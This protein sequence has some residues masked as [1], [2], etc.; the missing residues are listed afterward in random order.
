MG[1]CFQAK[2]PHFLRLGSVNAVTD[3]HDPI[4]L[5]CRSYQF[6]NASGLLCHIQ[7]FKLCKAVLT[8]ATVIPSI[9][10]KI[11][12]DIFPETFIGET[13]KSHLPQSFQV[14]FPDQGLFLKIQ[15]L[16]PL[17][18]DQKFIH[19][20][21]LSLVVKDTLPRLSVPACTACFLVVAFNIFGHIVMDHKPDIRFVNPHT[22]G[23]GSHHDRFSVVDKVFLVL[24]LLPVRKSCMIP[25]CRIAFPKKGF[26]NLFY[27]LPGAAVN[28]AA[29]LRIFPQILQKGSRLILRFFH[30]EIQ[31]L[32]VI[33]CNHDLRIP[34]PQ[35]TENIFSYRFCS[36]S[37][38]SS[39]HRPFGKRTDKIYDLQITRP[40]V[41][42]PLR[43]AVSLIHCHH[44]NF[45]RLDQREKRICHQPFRGCIDDLISSLPCQFHGFPVLAFSERTVYVSC[46]DASCI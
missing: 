1:V 38:I 43:N 14:P 37:C 42:S 9:L 32:P 20:H 31:V 7:I 17:L 24:L 12:E 4:A 19:L 39:D 33:T 18:L 46:M 26:M 30:C 23:I 11:P 10:P 35:D 45:H 29:F 25:Y 8:V 6:Q 21:I 22:E 3:S 16:I 41:L 13:V 15:L 36:C 28:N 40:E 27:R 34:K 2:L 44:G 5:S